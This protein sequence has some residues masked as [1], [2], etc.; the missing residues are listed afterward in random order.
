MST[1][2]LRGEEVEGH[3]NYQSQPSNLVRDGQ[4]PRQRRSSSSSISVSQA[5]AA[6]RVPSVRRMSQ[7]RMSAP[8]PKKGLMET[9]RTKSLGLLAS[10]GLITPP[11]PDPVSPQSAQHMSPLPLLLTDDDEQVAQ[12]GQR[13]SVLP[14]YETLRSMVVRMGAEAEKGRDAKPEALL[15]F[16]QGDALQAALKIASNFGGEPALAYMALH[17]LSQAAKDV[18][19]RRKMVERTDGAVG[20]TV[21]RLMEQHV[22]S[23]PKVYQLGLR[24]LTALAMDPH[25]GP[26]TANALPLDAAQ[27]VSE[28]QGRWKGQGQSKQDELAVQSFVE[29][30]GGQA[31]AL[32]GGA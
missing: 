15:E 32:V 13:G 26:V 3:A 4:Q 10:L 22:A 20:S 25:T 24:A 17:L 27:R 14:A 31:G 8:S 7:S 23:N 21:W 11:N 16:A 2:V 5:S 28:W 1:L 18:S 29:A 12:K 19:A 30:M 9:L 6:V